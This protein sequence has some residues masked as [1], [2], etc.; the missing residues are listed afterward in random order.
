[1]NASTAA[2]MKLHYT[3]LGA[4]NIGVIGKGGAHFVRFLKF[5]QFPGF[6]NFG[7]IWGRL[8]ILKISEDLGVEF[9]S[10]HFA[11]TKLSFENSEI[12]RYLQNH[13]STPNSPKVPK[14]RK[15][16]KL[17]KLKKMSYPLSRLPPYWW[18]RDSFR[19]AQSSMLRHDVRI[20]RAGCAKA[21]VTSENIRELRLTE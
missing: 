20:L 18:L 3:Q 8:A 7:T 6:R 15:L 19:T 2:V 14:T 10:V 21:L 1:M 12:F 5:S 16:R 13:Q 11:S 4:T 17:K 9:S